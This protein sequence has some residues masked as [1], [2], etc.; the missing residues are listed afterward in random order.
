MARHQT[1]GGSGRIE[2][3]PV[4]TLRSVVKTYESPA[5]PY[6]ALKGVDLEILSGEFAAVI[7]KSGCGKSTLINMVTGIDRPSSGEVV[8][9]GTAIQAMSEGAIASWRGRTIGVV[10]QFFQLLP[11]LNLLENVMLPMD[12]CN[13]H[14]A[15]ERGPIALGLLERVGLRSQAG[16]MPSELSGGQQQRVA[17]ARALANDPPLIVADEPTGNLDSRTAD[18]IFEL[19][20]ELV[21]SGKTILMVT[22]DGELARRAS[23]TV[24]V[25]DG[26]VVNQHVTAAL[27]MLDVDQFAAATTHM[28][29]LEFG[30]GEYI[31]R[32]GDPAD[33]F[34]VLVEGEVE[35]VLRH[36]GHELVVDRLGPGSYF[37]EM[38]LLK[39]GRRSAS[40]RAAADGPVS[41][42]A[43]DGATFDSLVRSSEY[44]RH[45]FEHVV[46]ARTASNRLRTGG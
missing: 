21:A 14:P 41:L 11:T 27:S 33:L 37:G 32:Q 34:Y 42:M 18:Q 8:V 10:F 40:V 4:V 23:R 15:S 3:S 29:R 20:S 12:F 6:T 2:V 16:K 36:H 9:A 31:I 28:T 43:L 25:A 19:F 22:H 24:L 30:A 5:G 38:A 26:E 1:H 46:E 39:G 7:G 45:R 35:I 44:V 17:I 13:V